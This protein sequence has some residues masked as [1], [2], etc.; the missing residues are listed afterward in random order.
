[1]HTTTLAA[2]R[3]VL[4]DAQALYLIGTIKSVYGDARLPT[5]CELSIDGE[6]RRFPIV[7][8]LKTA[9]TDTMYGRLIDTPAGLVRVCDF[10]A[11]MPADHEKCLTSHPQGA[12]WGVIDLDADT[13]L[14]WGPGWYQLA[15][16]DRVDLMLPQL[17]ELAFS[18]GENDPAEPLTRDE[19]VALGFN[20]LRFH[21]STVR[22]NMEIDWLIESARRTGLDGLIAKIERLRDAGAEE[23]FERLVLPDVGEPRPHQA[24]PR[25]NMFGMVAGQ[26]SLVAMAA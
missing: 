22:H 3:H 20:E 5:M 1:M 18:H 17:T 6:T 21:N 10:M 12:F 26:A 8:G 15:G 13:E 23:V 14:T 16:Q 7:P 4:T 19:I 25:A 2:G 9:E 11:I 24:L